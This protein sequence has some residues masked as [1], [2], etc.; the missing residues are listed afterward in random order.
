[1]KDWYILK[2]FEIFNWWTF[3]SHI[4]TFYLNDD[5]TVV[6][7]DNWSW[8]STVVDAFVSLLVP[9]RDRKYNLSASDWPNKKTRNE[10]TYI[11]WAYK[12]KETEEWIQTAFL[13]W[14][15]VWETT[16]SVLLWYFRNNSGHEI[17]LAT[18]FRTTSN[19][20]EKF[21]VVSEIEL[22][23][24]EDFVDIINN[25]N[26]VNP[27]LSLKNMLKSKKETRVYNKFIDYKE[28]YSV[29][30]WLKQNA[31]EL[32]NKVVSLKEIKDLNS[33]FRENMLDLNS[34]ILIEF[35]ECEKNYL[36][37]KD[38][39]EKI[40]ESEE[41]LKIL[42]PF[43]ENKKLL[44]QKNIE[45]EKIVYYQENLLNYSN[46]LETSLINNK[47]IKDKNKLEILEIEKKDLEDKIS[48]ETKE[49]KQ[50]EDLL[51]N[52]D[53][54]K[55]IKE[56]ENSINFLEKDKNFREYSYRNY[57]NYINILW[58]SFDDTEKKFNE[59][60]I[61]INEKYNELKEINNNN[62]Q[63]KISL[64]TDKRD[65]EIQKKELDIQLDY[66]KKRENLLPEKLSI[67]RQK[68]SKATWI[69]EENLKFVC[70][71]IRVKEIEKSWQMSI[72]KLFHSFWQELLVPEKYLHQV[73]QFVDKNNLKWKLKYNKIKSNFELRSYDEFENNIFSKI[74][75]KHNTDFYNWLKNMILTKFNYV[76]V[77]D[78]NNE[79]N[80]E[81]PLIL[82]ISWLIKNKFSYLK[83][84]RPFFEKDYILWWDNKNKIKLLEQELNTI[85]K[86]IKN[87]Q[88]KIEEIEKQENYFEEFKNVYIKLEDI[89]T[90][91]QIDYFSINDDINLKQKEI[92]NLKENDLEL[93][94]YREKLEKLKNILFN[95]KDKRDKKLWEISNIL[96]DL[97]HIENRL[98]QINNK[99]KDID[100]LEIKKNF[101]QSKYIFSTNIDLNN[102][103]DEKE[104]INK[105]II[106]KKDRLI[107]EIDSIKKKMNWYSSSYKEYRM[108]VS[109]KN[110]LWTNLPQDEFWEYLEKEY[111]KIND[112][113]LYKYREKFEK[114]FRD[115]LF[116][117]LTDFFYTLENEAESI[118]EKIF[119]INKTLKTINYSRDTYIEVSIK[120]NTKK[121]DGIENFKKEF[122]EKVI[123]KRELD[124]TDKLK[125]FEE[126]KWLI[127]KLIDNENSR[128]NNMIDVRNWFLFSIKELY[129]EDWNLKDIYESSSWK[130]WWQTI[131]LAYSVLA[132]ALLY[133]YWVKEENQNILTNH[134]S[135]SFRLVVIDEVFAKLDIDNSRYVLDLF[136]KLDLQLFIITPTNTIN[137]LE[138][139]VNT[140]YFIAN[141]DWSKSLKNKIDIKSRT[142]LEEKVQ[143]KPQTTEE[144]EYIQKEYERKK[145]LENLKIEMF[146]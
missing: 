137:V 136:K 122:R 135:K 37:V 18:F 117:L 58:F 125:A 104:Q 39:Y 74:D 6:S 31:I 30:F 49:V 17:S 96:S 129:I 123:N 119:L 48:M 83:D 144:Q 105:K 143:E 68:I 88:I 53:T 75:I 27:I 16:F 108:S 71:L 120:N 113:E 63:E 146:W 57:K 95:Y 142:K 43:I 118:K 55:R 11:R 8:K 138:D 50:I 2:K 91:S 115:N 19:W 72:E 98:N 81:N 20:I 94:F 14:N 140:I 9:S 76:C 46:I 112:E 97:K 78:I 121:W 127:E 28:D 51:E 61:S 67:I 106:N 139:Y 116:N 70:E 24:K 29:L 114:E 101:E 131:K 85:I 84:D 141:R 54:T 109:E 47:I 45:K 130:S 40:I 111:H 77:E 126:I 59:N 7:W 100:I 56:L 87:I 82:T 66:Y 93:K 38:I 69:E 80:K 35:E 124:L 102:L 44:E 13:R 21:Y 1:M 41:K 32:F 65:L 92:N 64:L 34:N 133:Q 107:E 60:T 3:D 86:K 99:L 134:N 90:Y 5:I 103:N 52:S 73:N 62:K 12:N 15:K 10:L 36:W 145:D 128:R 22:Y 26:S 110:E 25:S 33:F 4:E 89:K 42:T 132:S 23:L 79:K